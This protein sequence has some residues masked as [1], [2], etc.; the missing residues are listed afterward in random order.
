MILKLSKLVTTTQAGRM[1]GLSGDHVRRLILEGKLGAEKFGK[2]WLIKPKDLT[3]LKRK[4][5]ELKR[6]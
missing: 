6:K 3:R 4:R 5:E 2:L 1:V